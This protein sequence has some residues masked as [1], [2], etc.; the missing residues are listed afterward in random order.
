M[1]PISQKKSL[2]VSTDF[3][4]R[5]NSETGKWK[6]WIGQGRWHGDMNL[7]YPLLTSVLSASLTFT[8]LGGPQSPFLGLLV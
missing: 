1:V 4:K 8:N 6:I 5:Y 7:P 2:L 3:Y